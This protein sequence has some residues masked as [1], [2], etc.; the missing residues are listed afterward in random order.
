MIHSLSLPERMPS[1]G[2]I[3]EAGHFALET[4]FEKIAGEISRFMGPSK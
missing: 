2:I 1:V 3:L 4:H